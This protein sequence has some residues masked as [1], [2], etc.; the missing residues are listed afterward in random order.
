M[1]RQNT[2]IPLT[3]EDWKLLESRIAAHRSLQQVVL[4][5]RIILLLKA[6]G[7]DDIGVARKLHLN[8]HLCRLWRPRMLAGSRPGPWK[9][10]PGHGSKPRAGLAA[11]LIETALSTKPGGQT[12]RSS[13]GMAREQ[14]IQHSA[15]ARVWSEHG[16]KSRRHFRNK[17]FTHAR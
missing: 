17:K 12:H 2:A 4:C 13:R 14:G 6:D 8:R 5:C 16:I 11:K 15:V 1:A 3:D 9:V 7:M 10:A